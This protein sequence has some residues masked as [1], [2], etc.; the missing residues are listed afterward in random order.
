MIFIMKP[1]ITQPVTKIIENDNTSKHR[2]ATSGLDWM[3]FIL[4][5]RLKLKFDKSNLI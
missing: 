1:M 3:G 2:G 4:I 5:V